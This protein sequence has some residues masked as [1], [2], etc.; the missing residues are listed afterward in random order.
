MGED[1]NP[2]QDGVSN[3]V[4]HFWQRIIDTNSRLAST[5]R[6]MNRSLQSNIINT[7]TERPRMNTKR[8]FG[9]WF[10]SSPQA[11]FSMEVRQFRD[12]LATDTLT[13]SSSVLDYQYENGRR[14][15]ALKQGM[16]VSWK[17]WSLSMVGIPDVAHFSHRIIYVPEWWGIVPF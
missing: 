5:S 16:W 4:P 15:H 1:T 10:S 13:L 8:W 17:C 7:C 11:A 14:Y 6:G 3:P 9:E 12:T 2:L